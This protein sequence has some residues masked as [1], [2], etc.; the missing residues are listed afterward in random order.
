MFKF[1][2][3]ITFDSFSSDFREIVLDLSSLEYS[4]LAFNDGRDVRFY[5]PDGEELS[6]YYSTWN[7]GGNSEARIKAQPGSWLLMRYGATELPLATATFSAE[8]LTGTLGSEYS[9]KVW[10]GSAASLFSDFPVIWSCEGATLVGS[11]IGQTIE[12][13]SSYNSGSFTT[14]VIELPDSIKISHFLGQELAEGCLLGGYDSQGQFILIRSS[15]TSP[16]TNADGETWRSGDFPHPTDSFSS[17]S[18]TKARRG[19]LLNEGKFGQLKFIF[20][21][22]WQRIV[23]PNPVGYSLEDFGLKVVFNSA[24]DIE[25]GFMREDCSDLQFFDSSKAT[26]FPSWLFSGA[27]STET[28]V[29]FRA[30]LGSEGGT[31]YLRHH[32]LEGSTGSAREVFVGADDFEQPGYDIMDW[33]ATTDQPGDWLRATRQDD[34]ELGKKVMIQFSGTGQATTTW[35]LVATNTVFPTSG[36]LCYLV[37]Q[38]RSAT[39]NSALV[40]LSS[41]LG[42][43]TLLYF[44]PEGTF[45]AGDGG[46]AWIQI[47]IPWEPGTYYESTVLIYLDSKRYDIWIDGTEAATQL[48]FW[49]G[50]T[51]IAHVRL[52]Q[53]PSYDSTSYT[54]LVLL[55]KYVSPEPVGTLLKEEGRFFTWLKVKIRDTATRAYYSWAPQVVFNYSTLLGSCREDFRDLWIGTSLS[56]ASSWPYWIEATTATFATLRFPV[57]LLPLETQEVYIRLGGSSYFLG[58][59]EADYWRTFLMYATW[60]EPGTGFDIYSDLEVFTT[61]GSSTVTRTTATFTSASKSAQSVCIVDNVWAGFKKYLNLID[62]ERGAIY[63]SVQ[64]KST[65]PAEVIMSEFRLAYSSDNYWQYYDGAWHTTSIPFED[66]T[67]YKATVIFDL[68]NDIW[69]SWVEGTSICSSVA[70]P[71]TKTHFDIIDFCFW[72][73][74]TQW[75]DDI[76]YEVKP[77]QEPQTEVALLE[78]VPRPV[79]KAILVTATTDL[80]KY[81]VY[82]EIDTSDLI[83]SSKCRADLLDFRIIDSDGTETPYWFE[84]RKKESTSARI[85]FRPPSLGSGEAT[86]FLTY[87][88]SNLFYP[89]SPTGSFSMFETWDQNGSAVNSVWSAVGTQPDNNFLRKRES[90]GGIDRILKH[91]RGSFEGTKILLKG[92]LYPFLNCDFVFET[93]VYVATIYALMLFGIRKSDDSS[94]LGAIGQMPDQTINLLSSGSWINTGS[95]LTYNTWHTLRMEFFFSPGTYNTYWDGDLIGSLAFADSGTEVGYIYIGEHHELAT[96]W[97]DDITVKEFNLLKGTLV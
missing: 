12:V 43:E 97:V 51:D 42:L 47:D 46:T 56:Q 25:K 68:E 74:G 71:S 8:V 69:S 21:S 93:R 15:E 39:T 17:L 79:K 3:K 31:F 95:V 63:F 80:E 4:H 32:R 14:G 13:D 78:I 29:Y 2:R 35:Y 26:L 76:K 1:E 34:S 54:S 19:S 50:G 36:T 16:I 7:Y 27:N 57:D 49:T 65:Y 83:G 89:Q 60:D 24:T 18:W 59:L 23:V 67:F 55:R 52:H 77:H 64:K 38:K 90:F 40:S 11:G 44:R 53:N 5:A 41:G 75:I 61:E 85:Y 30:T 87:G 72:H 70:I 94:W 96:F 9:C 58:D 66:S 33:W 62:Q 37:K 86:F 92:T 45:E 20:G 6:Y 22:F 73:P 28:V 84:P 81:P 82:F 10:G 88:G 91:F 48:H